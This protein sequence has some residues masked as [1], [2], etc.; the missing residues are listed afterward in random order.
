MIVPAWP[1]GPVLLFKAIG[2]G[3]PFPCDNWS[4]GCYNFGKLFEK[5][6][7]KDLMAFKEPLRKPVSVNI[8]TCNGFSLPKTGGYGKRN[9]VNLLR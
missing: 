6:L 3:R 1:Y 7:K 8:L 9:R 2:L 5:D 4:I